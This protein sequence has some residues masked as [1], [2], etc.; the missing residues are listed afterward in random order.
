MIEE[1]AVD[2]FQGTR[3]AGPLVSLEVVLPPPMP[4]LPSQHS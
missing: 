4:P 2:P 1:V 3:K